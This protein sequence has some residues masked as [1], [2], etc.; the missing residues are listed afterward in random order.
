MTIRQQEGGLGFLD[1]VFGAI[2][3]I[4][5]EKKIKMAQQ[6]NHQES[7]NL[8]TSCYEAMVTLMMLVLI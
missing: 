5:G 1:P 2:S 6:P 3:S 8:L 7:R 4:F